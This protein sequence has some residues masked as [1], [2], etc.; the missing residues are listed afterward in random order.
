MLRISVNTALGRL[1]GRLSTFPSQTTPSPE[2][3]YFALPFAHQC[4][5]LWSP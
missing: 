5:A 3:K 1:V 2:K 4:L